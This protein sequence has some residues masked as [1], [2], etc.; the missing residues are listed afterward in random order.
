[1]EIKKIKIADLKPAGQSL[2][3]ETG[4]RQGHQGF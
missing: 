2:V 1:M 3:S 4:L